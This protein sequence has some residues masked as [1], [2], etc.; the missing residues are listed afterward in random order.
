MGTLSHDDHKPLIAL[1]EDHAVKLFLHKHP[2]VLSYTR[3]TS[4][5]TLKTDVHLHPQHTH[6]HKN[7]H[8]QDVAIPNSIAPIHALP[9]PKI[10]NLTIPPRQR[11]SLAQQQQ[12]HPH[13]LPIQAVTSLISTDASIATTTLSK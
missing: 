13:N 5:S 10:P 7:T 11:H 2:N 6:I 3:K 1:N 4:S 9:P 8:T 12:P